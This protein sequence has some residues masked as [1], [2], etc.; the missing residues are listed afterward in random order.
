[1]QANSQSSDSVAERRTKQL[2]IKQMEEISAKRTE[3]AKSDARTSCGMRETKNPS[4]DL[5]VDLF[6]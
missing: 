3:K 6:V 5:S 2:A 4:M 1:M